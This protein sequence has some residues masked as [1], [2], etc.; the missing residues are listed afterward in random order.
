MKNYWNNKVVLITGACRGLGLVLSKDLLSRGAKV[1]MH[2][3]SSPAPKEKEIQKALAEH[4]AIHVN[5]DIR[6]GDEV[7]NMVFQI[8]HKIGSC[9]MVIHNSGISSEASLEESSEEVFR[10]VIDTNLIGAVLVTKAILPLLKQSKGQVFFVSSLA[11]IYGMPNYLSYS[12]SKAAL[13]PLQEGLELEVKKHDIFVGLMYL[14]FV[15]NDAVKFA[16]NANG[17]KIP[18]PPRN[19]RL[20]ITK[21]RASA[22]ILKAIERK[23]RISYSDT[24]GR[25]FSVLKF[26][27][28]SFVRFLINRAQNKALK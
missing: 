24:T 17:E 10:Q 28:P 2:S 8:K 5:A 9:D 26:L 25:I 4:K 3:W 18:V 21:E 19:N 20:I 11:A 27:Y 12:M 16:L 23:K 7:S 1:I 15:E 22:R 13:V 14:G 6:S